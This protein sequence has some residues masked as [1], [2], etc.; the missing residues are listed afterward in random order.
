[1]WNDTP[2]SSFIEVAAL[3]FYASV[4]RKNNQTHI[5]S[6]S[7]CLFCLFCLPNIQNVALVAE[8]SAAISD[9]GDGD[10]GLGWWNNMV[11]RFGG[12]DIPSLLLDSLPF[13]LLPER[14]C[15]FFKPWL[16]DEMTKNLPAMQETQVDPWVRNISWRREWL[17]TPGFLPGEFHGQRSL[18][19]YSPWGHK[20]SDTTEQLSACARGHTHTH[21]HIYIRER[22]SLHNRQWAH[23]YYRPP[24]YFFITISLK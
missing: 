9:Y 21:T 18:A 10:G 4:F 5:V 12:A 22:G 13:W 16:V 1:M 7:S 6:V 20:E 24:P 3:I 8:A 15:T 14:A 11:E 17:P 23:D 2:F 19:G